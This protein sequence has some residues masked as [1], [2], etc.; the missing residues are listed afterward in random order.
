[1]CLIQDG[2]EGNIQPILQQERVCLRNSSSPQLSSLH[3]P[4]STPQ[5]L[6]T[7]RMEQAVHSQFKALAAVRAIIMANV[8]AGTKTAASVTIIITTGAVIMA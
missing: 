1:M 8:A 7:K 4:V 2:R 3:S 6:F 5:S